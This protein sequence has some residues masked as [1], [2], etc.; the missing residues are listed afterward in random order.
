MFSSPA[1]HATV[2]VFSSFF[3][4]YHG[5][6][7]SS[8]CSL[9]NMDGS[10]SVDKASYDQ[11][12]IV[13][14]TETRRGPELMVH[15]RER[16]IAHLHAS[17]IFITLSGTFPRLLP[18]TRPVLIIPVPEIAITFHGVYHSLYPVRPPTQS[19]EHYFRSASQQD[20][21]G[22]WLSW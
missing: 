7:L 9:P 21:S 8:R 11:A 10:R 17:T 18:T 1:V 3:A 2:F 16:P 13:P 5:G 14:G 12:D 4:L 22:V 20:S 19:F 15:G 6:C